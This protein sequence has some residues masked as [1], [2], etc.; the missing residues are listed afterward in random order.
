[1]WGRERE[2]ERTFL[3]NKIRKCCIHQRISIGEQNPSVRLTR[4]TVREQNSDA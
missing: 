1:M 4:I 3:E 2:R